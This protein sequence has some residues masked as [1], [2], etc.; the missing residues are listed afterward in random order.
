MRFRQRYAARDMPTITLRNDIDCGPEKFWELFWNEEVQKRIFLQELHFP[1]WQVIE[2]KE[3]ETEIRRVVK[4]TPKLDAP[5]AVQKVLGSNF[6]YTEE[7]RF[8]KASKIYKF[9]VKPSA[10]ADKLK[11][12]GTVRI[13]AKGEG[14]VT[15]IVDLVMEAKIMMIGGTIEKITEKG[16]REG[17]E[18]SARIFNEYARK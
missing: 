15:R 3:T 12:E 9:V 8:D 16:Q 1:A 2:H 14:K 4:A 18:M 6:G 5:A 7:G 10:M 13:E 17:W 11:N